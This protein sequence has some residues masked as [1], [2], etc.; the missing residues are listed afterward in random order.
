VKVVA[1]YTPE[2][3]EVVQPLLESLD[4]W[5]VNHSVEMVTSRGSWVDNCAIKPEFIRR[6]LEESAE[7]ILYVDADAEFITSIE[8]E[9]FRTKTQILCPV[10]KYLDRDKWELISNTMYWPKTE[11]ALRIADEWVALQRTSP[12]E[13]DQ[14]TLAEI[15]NRN[16][17]SWNRLPDY[18]AAIDFMDVHAPAIVQHQASRR[19]KF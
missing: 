6:N 7:G 5:N 16:S 3:A 11:D 12:G 17:D 15:L 1:Y 9:Y 14:I 4:K 13:W 19:M 18:Y 8:W 2:Y 10:I